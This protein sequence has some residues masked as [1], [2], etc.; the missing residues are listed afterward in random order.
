MLAPALIK[1]SATSRNPPQQARVR[2]VSCVSSV[3]AFMYA[4][5]FDKSFTFLIY[6]HIQQCNFHKHIIVIFSICIQ[7][8]SELF[9]IE[10]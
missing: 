6:M 7:N 2:P 8:Y 3:W 9:I 4:P 10:D 1:K 5:V